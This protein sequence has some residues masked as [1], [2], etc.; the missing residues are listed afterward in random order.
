MEKTDALLQYFRQMANWMEIQA[1]DYESGKAT[2]CTGQQDD[3][4]AAA[5]RLRH[6]AANILTV[7][8][9]FTRLTGR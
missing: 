7:I 9:S 8:D 5:A 6:K 1:R 2:H 4:P 3:S